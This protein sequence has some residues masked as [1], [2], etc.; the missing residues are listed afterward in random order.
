[1]PYVYDETEIEWPE[2]DGEWEPPPPRPDQF[3]YYAPADFLGS[4]E[5]VH[6]SVAEPPQAVE[7]A[8]AAPG[9]PP[10]SAEE[11]RRQREKARQERMQRAFA[12]GVSALRKAGVQ[13]L[14]CRYD[15]G[16]DEGFSW[17][18]RAEMTDGAR[19][20]A[21][22][23]SGRLAEAG[24]LDRIFAAGIMHPSTHIARRFPDP[25]QQVREQLREFLDLSLVNEWATMLLGSSYGTG[26]YSMYGA[27]T[28]DL[29]ACTITDDR[30]ADP[31]VENIEIAT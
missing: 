14:Y 19:L 3:V 15:G 26:E 30:N 1:M 29:E 6:F 11:Q 4:P 17:L 27:F 18:D 24:L 7:L 12:L 8:P 25:E 31:V 5:P 21:G 20:D 13:R 10:L 22:A 16:N 23:I 2:D 28:V 9:E